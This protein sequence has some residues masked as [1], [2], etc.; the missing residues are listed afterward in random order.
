MDSVPHL[1]TSKFYKVEVEREWG[2][3]VEFPYLT[4]FVVLTYEKIQACKKILWVYLAKPCQLLGSKISMYWDNAPECGGFS[5]IF[6][7]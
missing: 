1:Y 5:P 7:N 3:V 6:V 4:V 2:V